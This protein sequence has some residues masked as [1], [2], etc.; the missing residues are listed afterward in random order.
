MV[1]LNVNFSKGL[2]EGLRFYIKNVYRLILY[3]FAPNR[4]NILLFGGLT[5]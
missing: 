3:D 5:I 4:E 2:I 1:C